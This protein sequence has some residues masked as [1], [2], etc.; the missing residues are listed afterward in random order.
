MKG[1]KMKDVKDMLRKEL[2]EYEAVIGYMTPEERKELREWVAAG[3]QAICNPYYLYGD[4]GHPLDYISAARIAEDMRL[5]PEDYHPSPIL[6][7]CG[8]LENEA[9]PF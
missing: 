5:N 7:L 1:Y 6:E 9:L 3:N 4:D 8:D 2:R